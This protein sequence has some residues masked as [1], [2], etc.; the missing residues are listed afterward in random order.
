MDLLLVAKE[1]DATLLLFEASLPGTNCA[2]CRV[3][4]C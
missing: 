4:P 2:A 1:L 3:M